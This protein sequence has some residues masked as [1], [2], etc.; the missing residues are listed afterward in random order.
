MRVA[1]RRT[2]RVHDREGMP[3][4]DLGVIPD[5]S[6]Y[7]SESADIHKMTKQDVLNDNIDLINHASSILAK[8]PIYKISVEINPNEENLIV[9]TFTENVTRLDVFIDDRPQLSVD[10][11]DNIAQFTLKKPQQNQSII[12]IEGYKEKNLVAV[13]RVMIED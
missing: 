8:L 12:K 7:D 10:V 9:K 1:I 11:V 5:A 13:H 6:Q 3:L 2:L 4:E